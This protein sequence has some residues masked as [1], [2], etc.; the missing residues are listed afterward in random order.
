MLL[1]RE[2]Q[3][4]VH[5]QYS[6]VFVIY[7]LN[8]LRFLQSKQQPAGVSL[9]FTVLFPL[10]KLYWNLIPKIIVT[11]LGGKQNRFKICIM[12]KL[13][14]YCCVHFT[15]LPALVSKLSVFRVTHLRLSVSASIEQSAV[16]IL[17]YFL[18]FHFR[19]I[20]KWY[21]LCSEFG[22]AFLYVSTT[23]THNI[24]LW[25]IIFHFNY[26]YASYAAQPSQ[27]YGQSA[28]VN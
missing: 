15:I 27:N 10:P 11:F 17:F 24:S 3:S 8:R 1:A 20:T 19:Y 2:C 16:F 7:L 4:H 18:P 26:R 28:Q 9:S 21:L 23:T 14:R 13:L 6:C 22:L 25:F 12:E 5:F